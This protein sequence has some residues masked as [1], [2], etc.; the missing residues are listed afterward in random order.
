MSAINTLNGRSVSAARLPSLK[1][2]FGN[3]PVTASGVRTYNAMQAVLSGDSS[4]KDAARVLDSL[5]ACIDALDTQ[6]ELA[7]VGF[8]YQDDQAESFCRSAAQKMTESQA[9][10]AMAVVGFL[11]DFF[12][13]REG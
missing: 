11:I 3:K 7:E 2:I 10:E 6:R 12:S 5:N 1:S 4:P 8:L 13:T 9:L